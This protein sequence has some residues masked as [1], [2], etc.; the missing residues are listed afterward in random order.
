MGRVEQEKQVVQAMINVYCRKK[1]HSKTLCEDCEALSKYAD[2]RLS[3]CRYGDNK[4][5][6]SH[7]STHCYAPKY[8]EQIKQVMRFSGPWMLI[9]HPIMVI[10]HIL[11]K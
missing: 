5:F 11:K 6:C 2:K 10:K 7:C 1:H 9:Y 3:C 8:K 4:G